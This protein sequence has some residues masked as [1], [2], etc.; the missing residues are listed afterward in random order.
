M[1]CIS[2]IFFVIQSFQ[3]ISDCSYS[4]PR[5]L[6]QN[7]LR[8]SVLKCLVPAAT[9]GHV[10]SILSFLSKWHMCFLSGEYM[11]QTNKNSPNLECN[12]WEESWAQ[13]WG[14]GFSQSQWVL[15][16]PQEPAGSSSWRWERRAAHS[17]SFIGV[18]LQAE[19]KTSF[20]PHGVTS[21]G[22]WK[23][24]PFAISVC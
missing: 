16:T 1:I 7:P 12:I 8:P 19:V 22:T 4:L 13:A 17:P 20:R 24:C 9:A 6:K 14:R 5:F 11:N 23:T 15:G 21:C 3:H 18:H 10:F 2:S